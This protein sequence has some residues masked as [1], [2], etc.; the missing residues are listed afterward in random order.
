MNLLFFNGC[1]DLSTLADEDDRTE[2]G[3]Y[4]DNQDFIR[5]NISKRMTTAGQ[6]QLAALWDQHD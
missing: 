2:F 6:K 4:I 5:G 1:H 3:L